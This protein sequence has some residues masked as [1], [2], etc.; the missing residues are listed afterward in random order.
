MK[1]V[2]GNKGLLYVEV[3]FSRHRL[4]GTKANNI[5]R[6]T[7]EDTIQTDLAY[8]MIQTVRLLFQVMM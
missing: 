6:E 7:V 3:K 8:T 5:D 2:E 1:Y 4:K